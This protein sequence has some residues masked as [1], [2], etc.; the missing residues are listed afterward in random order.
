MVEDEEVEVE[1]EVVVLEDF[2][3]TSEAILDE[4]TEASLMWGWWYSRRR[5]GAQGVW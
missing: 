3:K 2:E 4:A 5:E 1:V